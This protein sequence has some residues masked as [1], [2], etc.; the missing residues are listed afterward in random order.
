MRKNKIKICSAFSVTL[1]ALLL[2]ATL[3][4]PIKMFTVYAG[5][6]KTVVS[7]A[8]SI[9]DSIDPAVFRVDAA[10]TALYAENGKAVF[11]A[12]TSDYPVSKM[13]FRTRADNNR[14][15][16]VEQLFDYSAVFA[17]NDIAADATFAFTF[18]LPRVNMECGAED[19]ASLFFSV[20]EVKGG[21]KRLAFS[22]AERTPSGDRVLVEERAFV[23]PQPQLCEE[24]T[25]KLNVK[26]DNTADILLKSGAEE[27]KFK[28]I[29]FSVGT[30]GF[31]GIFAKGD[32]SAYIRDVNFTVYSEYS[33]PE[34]VDFTETFEHGGVD[35]YNKNL[36]HTEAKAS[37]MPDSS[38]SVK[39]GALVFNN[40]GN[41]FV[42]TKYMYSNFELNFDITHLQRTAAYNADK[43]LKNVISGFWGVSFGV[44]ET[45]YVDHVWNTRFLL[46]QSFPFEENYDRTKPYEG[47]TKYQLGEYLSTTRKSVN[48]DKTRGE[49]DLWDAEIDKR[50]DKTVNIKISLIDGVFKLFMKYNGEDWKDPVLEYDYGFTPLGYIRIWTQGGTAIPEKGAAYARAGTFTIDN[51]S[52]KNMDAESAKNTLPDPEF[53]SN[54]REQTPD[55]NYVTKPD[56]NDL[57]FGESGGVSS[58]GCNAAAGK[59]SAVVALVSV[60]GATVTVWRKR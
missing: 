60:V 10:S 57:S 48:P 19:S 28:G 40:A 5:L 59:T 6:D 43:S 16:G 44:R 20:T 39:D 9:T 21:A 11:A 25:L 14:E 50:E 58:R 3:F 24:F 51:L 26:T 4:V 56:P 29:S 1:L 27:V 36:I 8:N 15:Y 54:I 23:Y 33:A 13:T 31:V 18:G 12:T 30:N 7:D 42:A 47:K 52:V 45:G 2:F 46:F 32:V 37:A 53:S 35:C 17:I 49:I 41:G 55:Y 34:N 38:L 22:V